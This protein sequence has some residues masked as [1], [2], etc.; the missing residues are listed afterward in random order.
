MDP[1]GVIRGAAA[2]DMIR[3]PAAQ[4][5]LDWDDGMRLV[6]MGVEERIEAIPAIKEARRRDQR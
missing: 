5:S 4:L 2:E 3:V 6:N 1:I